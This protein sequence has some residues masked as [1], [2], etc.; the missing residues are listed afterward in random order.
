[1]V[2]GA[3]ARALRLQSQRGAFLDSTGDALVTVAAIAGL[4]G[5]KWPF[6]AEHYPALLLVVGLYVVEVGAALWRYGR[7]SSF[8][9]YLARAAA[10]AQGFFVLSLF[11]FGYRGW[12]FHTMV[13]LS[14]VAYL[15][16]ILLLYFLPQWTSDVRGLYWVLARRRVGL[17]P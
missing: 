4:L 6:V 14:A 10:Y 11:F 8:H 7:L 12:V 16:E 17:P 1:M 5:L 3:L 15:E 13:V 9:T 2:D